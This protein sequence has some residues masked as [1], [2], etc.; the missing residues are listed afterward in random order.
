MV[1]IYIEDL[2]RGYWF[3]IVDNKSYRQIIVIASTVYFIATFVTGFWNPISALGY[4][5]LIVSCI[6]STESWSFYTATVAFVLYAL[7]NGI[8]LII[9]LILIIYVIYRYLEEHRIN[10]LKKIALSS[11]SK[12]SK[13]RFEQPKVEIIIRGDRK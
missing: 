8:A 9:M 10:R 12:L 13:V 3:K 7:T 11:P 2:L 5:L 6:K 1:Q 4:A